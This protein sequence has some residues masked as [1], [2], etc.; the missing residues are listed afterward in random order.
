MAREGFW[1]TPGC[2]S[3][4]R[5]GLGTTLLSWKAAESSPE[6]LCSPRPI[7]PTCTLLS[8]NPQILAE[9]QE[10]GPAS[11]RSAAVLSSLGQPE[12]QR[13]PLQASLLRTAASALPHELSITLGLVR[14]GSKGAARPQFEQGMTGANGVW[15]EV[16]PGALFCPTA[17]ASDCPG[18]RYPQS[19]VVSASR[20]FSSPGPLA[21]LMVASCSNF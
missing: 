15:P 8:C 18:C 11:S 5:I 17:R 12:A 2:R 14:A 19:G 10:S 21:F 7:P 6:L 16:H 13:P 9:G 4:G 1:R 20:C 3:G